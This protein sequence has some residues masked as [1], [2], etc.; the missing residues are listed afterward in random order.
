MSK[1]FKTFKNAGPTEP[2]AREDHIEPEGSLP[3]FDL[4]EVD[5]I[6]PA[7]IGQGQKDVASFILAIALAFND[8]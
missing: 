5:W 8:L 7:I 2:N 4:A 3:D 6:D 1:T